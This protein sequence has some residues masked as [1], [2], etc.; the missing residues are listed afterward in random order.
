MKKI[1]FILLVFL[2]G[3][4]FRAISQEVPI[5]PLKRS[6]W[7]ISPRVGYDIFP[8]YDN[9]TPYI[10]YK[11]GIEAGISI[12]YYWNWFGLGSDFDFIKN[13]PQNTF[14][15]EN[16]TYSYTNTPTFNL[17]EQSI[18]R[19]FMGVGPSFKYNKDKFMAELNLRG[20]FGI[21]NG[22]R[23]EY[24]ET[25][26]GT[27]LLLNFHAGYN[28]S[29]P[30]AKAQVRF[31]YFVKE[32]LGLQFGAYY[33]NHFKVTELKDSSLGMSAGYWTTLEHRD[34]VLLEE[35]NQRAEPCDCHISSAGMFAGIVYQIPI[36]P[37]VKPVVEKKKEDCNICDTYA[38]AVTA[39]DKF[40]AEILPDTDVAVKDLEGNVVQT[41][42][43]N[44]FGV[45]VFNNIKPDNYTIEG[46]LY[47]V[48]LEKNVTRKEE[49]KPKETLQ[50]DILY[51]D[52]DFIL[53]GKTVICNTQNPLPDVKVFL[54]NKD[55]AEEKITRT[56]ENGEF[57]FHIKQKANY[58]IYGKKDNYLSQI[59]KISTKDYDRNATLFVKLEICMD[60]V[61]C[62][63]SITLKNI[64]YDLDKYFIREDAKPELNRLVRFMK[65]NPE[66]KVELSSH[67]DSRASNEY[68]RILSENRAKAAVDYLVS[69]GIDRSRLIAVGYGESKLL[70]H[71]A[72]GVKCS[73]EEHQLNRRTEM[74]VICPDNEKK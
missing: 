47:D 9:N 34:A 7:F 40:T 25:S 41:G 71:C 10:D 35:F 66:I 72:D 62:G 59:E 2:L 58:E 53:K 12:D 21:I 4:Q 33:L 13:K 64:H 49:F 65:D 19:M 24:S 17:M 43:T 50:K 38:L 39:R 73:E 57:L 3:A 48:P 56:G 55:M 11:G 16:I 67:T 27:P 63:T 15:G 28:S 74:K 29:G 23:L 1:I 5:D 6:G 30:A 18:T 8:F 61:D 42:T 70:N 44:K 14:N 68:N 32:Y 22:G 45:V 36:K 69:Q 46:I 60:K 37:K 26:S 20:G 52:L 51:S 54:T 31:T